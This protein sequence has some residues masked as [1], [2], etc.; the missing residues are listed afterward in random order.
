[1]QY[2]SAVKTLPLVSM[3]GITKA[4]GSVKVLDQVDF[5][6]Y[7]G[8]VH[9]LAGENGA[10]KSTLMKILAGAYADYQGRIVMEERDIRPSSPLDANRHGIAAI[11]Q[12]LSLIPSMSVMDNLF[13]G[14]PMTRSGFVRA[15]MHRRMAEEALDRAGVDVPVTFAVEDL[16][17][18]VQQLIEITKAIRLNA[19]VLLMD[20]PSS[21]LNAHDVE[22]LFTLVRQLKSE[23]RGIVYITHRLEEMHRLADRITVLRDGKLVGTALAPELP[24]NKLIQW[25]VGREMEEQFPR[26]TPQTSSEALR[27]EHFSVYKAGRGHRPLVNQVSLSVGRGEILGIGGLQGSGASE[28]FLGLF[29]AIPKRTE[30]RVMIEGKPVRIRSPREAI[31]NGVALL[32]NDRKATG[33]I[34]PMSV[35][36]NLC[37]ANLRSLS[38]HGW[39]QPRAET[40]MA[41]DMGRTLQLR[42]ASYDMEAGDL[43]G[44]NQQKV[45]IGKWLSTSPR[46][47]LLDEP[48]RGIDVGAKHEIYQLMN[49]L[50]TRGI[51][52]LLVTSEMPELLAM[53]DR[54]IVMHRGIITAEFSRQEATAEKVLEAALGKMNGTGGMNRGEENVHAEDN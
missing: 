36:A 11:H 38:R 53:S 3:T 14:H 31:A 35:T 33:L 49:E 23:N 28:F 30:G 13:L 18:S 40:R 8:E 15:G 6:I 5:T 46:I 43:S 41:A 32:T 42:A 20:E 19:R 45:A 26:H 54:I 44:G 9:I 34:T 50:T 29:G 24:E 22:T 7:P 51:S 48:T 52:I 47:M 2:K 1:M 17:I 4:F 12:E 39:R 27:V 16:P 25:M 10:G 37:M 21:A